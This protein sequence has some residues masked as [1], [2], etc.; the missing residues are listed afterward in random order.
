MLTLDVGTSSV[1]A[2]LWDLDAQPLPGTEARVTYE[3]RL[4]GDGGTE[5]DARWLATRCLA[6][7][8]SAIGK[9]RQRDRVAAIGVSSF[10][11]GLLGLDGAHR[12][13]TPVVLWSDQRSWRQAAA[14]R[15]EAA[16]GDVRSRTGAPIHPSYWP[17]KLEWARLQ[18]PDWW[19]RV[20]HWVSFTDYLYL[21]LF[22]ELGT[23]ASMASGTGLRRLQDGRWDAEL[24]D[25]LQ[26]D[27]A[28]L[29]ARRETFS[30]AR[31]AVAEL[32]PASG[33]MWL[34]A[35]GDG[36][37]ATVGT[38]CERA[39][40][41]ALTIGTS[42]A[43]RATVERPPAALEPGLWCY[44]SHGSAHVVGG[45]FSNGGNLHAWLLRHLR[46]EA[47]V[48]ERQL[49]CLP[50]ASAALTFLPLLAGERSPG[51]APRAWGSVSGLTEGT[52]ALDIA[53]AG[54]EAVAML[55]RPVDRA[56]DVMTGEPGRVVIGG[57]ALVQSDAWCQV[58]AD[59]IG[60]PV[61]AVATEE[62]SSRGAA[63]IALHQ[64]GASATP[65]LR[66]VRTWRPRPSAHEVYTGALERLQRLYDATVPDAVTG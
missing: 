48:L 35:A 30:G 12:P 16:L 6:V 33:A 64:L 49:R 22:G 11:H 28:A 10:W 31:L 47:E 29:P 21:Q 1:R 36:A 61:S 34:S 44:L 50:P 58:I 53:R 42:A 20:R 38:D 4:T 24:L 59:V 56:L 63:V 2:L 15:S 19:R 46:V 9:A 52:S 17:A 7:L 37:M 45:S 41:R 27:P 23:G 25:R 57:G 32:G 51:F 13:V 60:K 40:R 62:A 66:L 39:G 18:R 54:M 3:P 5:L 43:L 14:L 55:L 8:G 26:V 65:R